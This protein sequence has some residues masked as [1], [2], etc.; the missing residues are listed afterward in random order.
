V[1]VLRQILEQDLPARAQ[2]IGSYLLE[3]LRAL[4]CKYDII[5]QVRGAGL[6]T[7]MLLAA[8]RQSGARLRDEAAFARALHQ[9]AREHELLLRPYNGYVVFAPPLTISEPEIDHLLAAT[10]ATFADV[11]ARVP[12]R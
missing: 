4:Q 7:V 8:D 10:D 9:R 11:L 12:V 6:Y 2:R 3:G 5:A 1:A